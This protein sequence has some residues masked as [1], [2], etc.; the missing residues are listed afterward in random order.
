MLRSRATWAAV[1][2]SLALTLTGCGGGQSDSSKAESITLY[3]CV[4]DTTIGPIIDEL[5][6]GQPRDRGD[7]CTGP[8]PAT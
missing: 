2:T 3:T 1:L 4:N 5:Q 8:P 6:E 7:V